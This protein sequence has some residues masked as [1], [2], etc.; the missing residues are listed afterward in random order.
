LPWWTP[1]VLADL[2]FSQE[3]AIRRRIRLSLVS[4]PFLPP[5]LHPLCSSPRAAEQLGID[6]HSTVS[7]G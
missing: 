2:L 1:S 5:L 4:S 3:V 6:W 7:A